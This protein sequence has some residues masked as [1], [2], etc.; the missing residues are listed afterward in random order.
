M[1]DEHATRAVTAPDRDS[2]SPPEPGQRRAAA[3]AACWQDPPPR[4]QRPA[5]TRTPASQCICSDFLSDSLRRSE[6]IS[7]LEPAPHK[8]KKPTRRSG[9]P[10]PC[11]NSPWRELRPIASRERG[12]SLQPQFHPASET[13]SPWSFSATLPKHLYPSEWLDSVAM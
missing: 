11:R 10:G 12:E 1:C 5:H 6:F 3:R 4:P 2:C 8:V 13:R 9:I 7:L